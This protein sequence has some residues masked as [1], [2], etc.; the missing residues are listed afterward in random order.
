M[1]PEN[2]LQ[3]DMLDIIFENRNKQYGAY[4]L[5]K[6]YRKRLQFSIAGT[7]LFAA[8]VSLF[9]MKAKHRETLINSFIPDGAKL[10]NVIIPVREPEKPKQP[11]VK[12]LVAMVN[13][14]TPI[15]TDDNKVTDTLA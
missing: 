10:I 1:L 7:L 15:I 6:E 8:V 14:S 5:R 4:T 3:S 12:K 9:L 13:F 11:P 2:I